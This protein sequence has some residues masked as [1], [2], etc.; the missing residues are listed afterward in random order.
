M[1]LK[2]KEVELKENFTF[3]FNDNSFHFI[4]ILNCFPIQI[5][6][7]SFFPFTISSSVSLEYPIFNFEQK[8]RETKLKVIKEVLCS[9]NKKRKSVRVCV[10][11]G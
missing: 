4:L 10:G 1:K 7:N 2:E 11:D 3:P 5:N 8:R 9:V 6:A